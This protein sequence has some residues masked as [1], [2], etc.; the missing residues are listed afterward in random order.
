MESGLSALVGRDIKTAIEVMGYPSGKQQ[1]GDDTVYYWALNSSGGV[2]IPQTANTQGY[3]GNR[4]V[5]AQT[6][7]NQY[8]PMNYSCEI[9]IITANDIIKSWEYYGNYNGCSPFISRLG[10]YSDAQNK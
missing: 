10:A 8:I 6:T 7:Y 9:K 1:F 2:M 5:Y 3:V 4:P